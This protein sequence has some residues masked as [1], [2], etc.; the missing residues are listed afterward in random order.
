VNIFLPKRRYT[1]ERLYTA[2][3]QRGRTAASGQTTPLGAMVSGM[4]NCKAVAERFLDSGGINGNA[5]LL[6]RVVNLLDL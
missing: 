4:V 6:D 1:R 5:L 2:E 3:S